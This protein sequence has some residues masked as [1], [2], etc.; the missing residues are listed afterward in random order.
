MDF[1][2][3]LGAPGATLP[4]I[5]LRLYYGGVPVAV[6]AGIALT[7][8]SSIDYVLSGLPDFGPYRL[9][10]DFPAGVWSMRSWGG[11]AAPREIIVPIRETGLNAGSLGLALMVNGAPSGAALAV[12]EV[13]SP[14]DYK[15]S[16][17]PAPVPGE[18]WTL[19]WSYADFHG[20]ETWRHPST[21]GVTRL[22]LDDRTLEAF[23][24]L[25]RAQVPPPPL[26][27]MPHVVVPGGGFR[28]KN[29]EPY[30]D[31]DLLMDRGDESGPVGMKT[32]DLPGIF[33]VSLHV[34]DGDGRLLSTALLKLAVDCL[35]EMEV[36]GVKVYGGRK[37]Y[38]LPTPPKGYYSRAVDAPCRYLGP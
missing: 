31:L 34:K 2:L 19:R 6:G 25:W 21:A 29:Q 17:W 35:R 15:V 36:D 20:S 16:G 7:Q 28:P 22:D 14:G 8:V 11:P 23:A 12:A 32:Y 24:V 38:D 26:T 13:G 37:P 4:D 9:T 33:Q 5:G 1:D 3:P 18:R 27:A 10:Y 30:L